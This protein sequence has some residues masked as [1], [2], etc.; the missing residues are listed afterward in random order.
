MKLRLALLVPFAAVALTVA[1]CGNGNDDAPDAGAVVVEATEFAFDPATVS[2]AADTDTDITLD[3]VGVVE[4]DWTIDELDIQIYAEAG[5]AITQ[6]INVPAGTY[7][8]YCSIPGH[9]EAGMVG[10]L[11]VGS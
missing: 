4:H 3:N 5:E 10:T 6:T 11:N 7:E 9:R 1:A 8:I 2:I